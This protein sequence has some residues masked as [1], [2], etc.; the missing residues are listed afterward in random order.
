MNDM[1]QGIIE[2]VWGIIGGMFFSTLLKAFAEDGLIPSNMVIL[3]TIA[4][5]LAAIV[6]MFSFQTAGIVFT[7]GW[8]LG[9]LM[10]KDLLTPFDFIVYLVAPIVTLV[11]RAIMFFKSSD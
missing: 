8:I 1:R 9:A 10:L 11:I 2:A 3:F 7:L 5:L 6:T 4:G